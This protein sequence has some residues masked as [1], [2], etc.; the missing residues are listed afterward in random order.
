MF[1]WPVQMTKQ[2]I[3]V[4]RGI[5]PC[6]SVAKETDICTRERRYEANTKVDAWIKAF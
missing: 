5:H 6:S 4:D 2:N 1:G 3:L